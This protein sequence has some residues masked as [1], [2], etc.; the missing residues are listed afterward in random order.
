MDA[1]LF[2]PAEYWRLTDEQKR[3]IC[4]GCGSSGAFGWL[5]PDTMYLLNVRRACDIHDFMYEVGKT[6]ADKEEADRVFL[7]NMVRII[8]GRG[9]LF[10]RLRLRRAKKYYLAVYHFG[11]SAFWD[12]KNNLEEFRAPFLALY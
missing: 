8:N 2:A 4:N 11:G 10:R 1:K 5:V 12:G 9:G 7:N 3:G 6:Q